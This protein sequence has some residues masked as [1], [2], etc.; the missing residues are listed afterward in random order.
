M[1]SLLE[2]ISAEDGLV[3]C[4]TARKKE[5]VF[6]CEGRSLQVWSFGRCCIAGFR[7]VILRSDGFHKAG[8]RWLKVSS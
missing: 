8:M 4:A 1:M 3:R 6:V 5:K 2:E 7:T